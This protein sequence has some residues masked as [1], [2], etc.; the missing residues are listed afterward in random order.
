MKYTKMAVGGVRKVILANKHNK[1]IKYSNASN[2]IK[3]T[4]MAV[5]RANIIKAVKNSKLRSLNT[6]FRSLCR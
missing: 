2:L 3:Y 4:K 6:S 1:L 5:S